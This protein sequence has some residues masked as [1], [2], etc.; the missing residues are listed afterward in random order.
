MIMLF[1]RERALLE[2]AIVSPINREKRT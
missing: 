1:Q 2:G